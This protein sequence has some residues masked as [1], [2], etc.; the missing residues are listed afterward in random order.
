MLSVKYTTKKDVENDFEL[1]KLWANVYENS[2][3]D[4]AREFADIRMPGANA[5]MKSAMLDIFS[6]IDEPHYL[7]MTSDATSRI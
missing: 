3:E 1:R 5:N 7:R 2:Q 6:E 4:V